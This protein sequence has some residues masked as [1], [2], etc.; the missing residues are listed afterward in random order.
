MN[1]HNIMKKSGLHQGAKS[2][3]NTL[4]K[5][6]TTFGRRFFRRARRIYA[7]KVAIELCL[8]HQNIDIDSLNAQVEIYT[9]FPLFKHYE[10]KP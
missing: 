6:L 1:T 2:V 9:W 5:G 4:K 7:D 3:V 8:A 10:C